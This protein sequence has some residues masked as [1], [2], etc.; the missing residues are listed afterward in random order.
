MK[1]KGIH[2]MEL[3]KN[4]LIKMFLSS[5]DD[6]T[7]IFIVGTNMRINIENSNDVEVFVDDRKQKGGEIEWK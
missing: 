4:G 1:V 2:T 5:G 7:I 6:Q 3:T